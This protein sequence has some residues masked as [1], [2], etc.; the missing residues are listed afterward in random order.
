MLSRRSASRSPSRF[1]SPLLR[2]AAMARSCGSRTARRRTWFGTSSPALVAHSQPCSP[3]SR[4]G[5]RSRARFS[6]LFAPPRDLRP[7]AS[8][9]MRCVVCRVTRVPQPSGGVAFPP[10]TPPLP[11]PPYPT[12]TPLR[13]VGHRCRCC[14]ALAAF[15]LR[16]VR[17]LG[18]GVLLIPCAFVCG[19]LLLLL[20]CLCVDVCFVVTAVAHRRHERGDAGVL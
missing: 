19:V 7:L 4:R 13:S 20:L 17:R 12:P 8:A 10:P 18:V 14:F 11:H 1:C 2:A 9:A 5:P 16:F 3:C 6:S 15:V